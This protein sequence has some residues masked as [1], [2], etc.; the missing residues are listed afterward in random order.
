MT[1]STLLA[2][3]FLLALPGTARA[4]APEKGRTFRAPGGV[5][6]YYEVRGEGVAAALVVVNGGPGFDHGYLHCSDVWDRLAASRRVIFY[7]QRGNG[8]SSPLKA[9]QSCTIADQI[10]DLDALRAHVGCERMDL[11]GHSWGGY[12]AMAYAARHPG[13]VSR[14]IICDSAAPR[15]EDTIFLFKDVFP[16]GVERQSALAF[17]ETLGDSA[18]IHATLR[19]YF[20]MLFYSPENRNRYLAAARPYVYRPAINAALNADA[21]RFDLGPELPK[22]GFPTLVLTGRYDMNVAPAVAHRIHKAIP[23]SRFVVFERSGHL[24]FFEEPEAFVRT[25]EEF[26]RR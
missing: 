1:R 26:L 15:W 7:D 19:E 21:K 24:P 22:F 13:R 23:G 17:A 10:A 14:L 25:V 2:A 16:E 20:S 6:L 9:A 3:L 5:T 12:L 4:D 18:A 11:L 8:R